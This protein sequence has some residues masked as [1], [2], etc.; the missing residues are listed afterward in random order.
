MIQGATVRWT[1]LLSLAGAGALG[2]LSCHGQAAPPAG[3]V[4]GSGPG[5]AGA[6]GAGGTGGGRPG[7]AGNPGGGGS[8]G[9]MT[10]PPGAGGGAGGESPDASPPPPPTPAPVDAQRPDAPGIDGATPM[11]PADGGA[12][13]PGAPPPLARNLRLGIV[14]VG[15]GPFVRLGQGV[16]VVPLAMRN[17]PLIEGRP[18]FVRVHVTTEVGF[19]ARP[20][21]G[22]LTLEQGDSK[23][24]IEDRKMI[25]G[26]SDSTKL[27]ST[28]NFLVPAERIKP[29]SRLSVAVH[30]TAAVESPPPAVPP[31]FPAT[32]SV[33]L[34]VK[35][36]R[37]VL[38]LVLVPAVGVGGP[39]D[40]S[41]AR[42]K[43]LEN[44][45]FDVYP[46]QKL[47]VRWRQPLRFTTRIS[48]SEGFAALSEARTE[49]G[50][51]PAVYYHLMIARADTREA[52]LGIANFA[53]PTARDGARRIGITFLDPRV[54]DASVD[55]TSHEIGHNHGRS[56]APNCGA[57]GA[58]PGYP[59]MNGA[60]GVDG[61]SLS[62][63]VLYPR[64]MRF[65]IMGY[66][67]PTW[68]SDYTWSGLEQ[69]VRA[70]SAFS[71]APGMALAERSLQGFLT[72]GEQ[73]RWTLTAGALASGGDGA[74]P[75]PIATRRARL[76]FADGS[77]AD[78]PFA[79][80]TLSD[81]RTRELAI[82]L[83]PEGDLRAVE[84]L[85]D[86]TRYTVPAH[87]LAER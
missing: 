27:S 75:G 1:L 30:E 23:Q 46:V 21:R 63:G 34:G 67:S 9:G 13:A 82:D 6:G 10:E 52:F 71:T 65:D 60:L 7:I 5:Q 61:I 85:L 81:D 83:P 87:V 44:H 51:G 58:D 74:A 47:N 25:A 29:G 79:V 2:V 42:R 49:D 12:D 38:D 86:G 76:S 37:M 68:I 8:G 77:T 43:T 55:S 80:R 22:L 84:V 40:D 53:G 64:Q 70:V 62:E 24:E 32:G 14:E 73:P 78:A 39:I 17:A 54:A 31:R 11:P 45:M 66:C 20:L 69:R 16:T 18:L 15:Q 4:A 26:A 57:G 19:V 50:A 48:A 3:P 35:G 41:P 36:G 33:D 72:P 28:F 59:Y 56:H